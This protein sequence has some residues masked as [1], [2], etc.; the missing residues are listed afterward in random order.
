MDK[1]SSG[2][3]LITK[4]EKFYEQEIEGNF[5]SCGCH[6]CSGIGCVPDVRFTAV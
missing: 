4:S 5:V 3:C 2:L 1:S 6:L